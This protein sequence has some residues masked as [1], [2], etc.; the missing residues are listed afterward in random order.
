M[1]K[2]SQIS[3]IILVFFLGMFVFSCGQFNTKDEG[4]DSKT[5]EEASGTSGGT[6]NSSGGSGG[7]SGTDNSSGGTTITSAGFVISAITGSTT[8]AG[9]TATFTV[10]L[11][12][13]PT[14]NVSIALS[15]SDS[16]EGSVSPASLLFTSSN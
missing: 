1:M 11:K 7:D 5:I 3:F 13:Q 14:A 4:L 6:D 15:S 9:G 8:E 10:N 2:I 16:T 12:S